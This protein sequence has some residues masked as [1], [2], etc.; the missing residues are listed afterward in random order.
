MHFRKYR[1]VT[2]EFNTIT[3][4]N[5]QKNIICEAQGNSLI[6][7]IGSASAFVICRLFSL[8]YIYAIYLGRLFNIIILLVFGYLS[9]KKIPFGKLALALYLCMPMML[10]QTDSFFAV[11]TEC[12]IIILY[13]IFVI[14]GV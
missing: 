2:N 10:Q 12:N 5:E 6:S 13:S 14:Y 4:Y 7:Y 8:N 1:D 3:N 9:I 11:R